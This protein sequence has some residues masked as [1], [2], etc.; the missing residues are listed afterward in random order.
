MT[1][2]WVLV[3]I[4]A[5][6]VLAAAQR[7]P[8]VGTLLPVSL[9]RTLNAAKVHPGEPI[10]AE[11]MQD[12][13]NTPIRRG[14][15][16]L[17]SVVTADARKDGQATLAIRF[18]AVIARGQRFPIGANLRAMASF[19]EVEQAQIPEEVSSRG[20]TPESWN[21][22]QIGGDQVYRGGGSVAVGVTTVGEPNPYGVLAIPRIQAGQPCRGVVADADR[23][24]A[25]WLFSTDACG[26]YGY[27][28]L[29]IAHAGRTDPAGM[30]VLAADTG[31]LTLTSGSGLLLRVQ[32]W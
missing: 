5:S 11:V 3:A 10:R 6:P 19:F 28:N 17:G 24:Q 2:V 18:D 12:I 31:K 26:L 8:P 4:L 20:L 32:G 30:I 29:R 15:V 16:V 7:M 21:T 22:Q 23:P 27:S 1:S 9:N 25:F 14:A 13:P